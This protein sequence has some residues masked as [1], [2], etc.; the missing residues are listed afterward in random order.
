[1][2]CLS[3]SFTPTE[4]AAESKSSRAA[5]APSRAPLDTSVRLPF[6]SR[7]KLNIGPASISSGLTS[8]VAA[9]RLAFSCKRPPERSE[10]G[11]LSAATAELCSV[12]VPSRFCPGAVPTNWRSCPCTPGVAED[13][14][15]SLN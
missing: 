5:V 4:P 15:P 9:E 12:P 8:A 7:F 3:R 10:E 6:Y 1:M 13:N 2:L 14:G 11:R